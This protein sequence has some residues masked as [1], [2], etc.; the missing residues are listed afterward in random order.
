MVC[1]EGV[2]VCLCV[3]VGWNWFGWKLGWCFGFCSDVLCGW[4]VGIG[5]K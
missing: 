3:V 4:V 2:V 5:G 1:Y